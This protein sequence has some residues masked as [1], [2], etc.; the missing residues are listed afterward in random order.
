M[1]K[2]CEWA[3][4]NSLETEYHDKEWGVPIH[5]DKTLFEFLILEGMQAGLSWSII[6]RKR[7]KIR[8]AFDG[9]DYNKIANYNE[10]K[11]KELL[12]NKDIIRNKLK[13]KATISNSRAFIKIRG[14][15]G[16]FNNYIWGFVKNKPLQNCWKNIMEVPA[17]TK[18]SDKISLDLRKRG[19]KFVGSKI[20]YAFI[21]AVGLVNDHITDCFRH[22]QI[23]EMM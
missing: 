1:I 19:F 8:K 23:K 9:F 15:Y 17:N 18:L 13:I 14:K 20:I 2:R 11:V 22:K 10:N 5:D 7:D 3:E 6:L 12:G 21:Q 4:S 16:S